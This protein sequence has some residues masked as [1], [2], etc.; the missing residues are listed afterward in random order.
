VTGWLKRGPSGVILTNVS[1][2]AESAA[3]LLRDHAAGEL[4][5]RRRGGGGRAGVALLLAAQ[6]Q[7]AVDF[8]GWPWP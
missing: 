1:D 7:P 4:R 8:A 5:A 6:P 3:A 2:A